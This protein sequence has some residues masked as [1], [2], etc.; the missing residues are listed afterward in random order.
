MSNFT[1]RICGPEDGDITK[2]PPT[3][4]PHYKWI[5]WRGCEKTEH[6][7]EFKDKCQAGY[8][9]ATADDCGC[10]QDWDWDTCPVCLKDQGS[11]WESAT[12]R[13]CCWDCSKQKADEDADRHAKRKVEKLEH[14]EW[15]WS[16][17]SSDSSD[18]DE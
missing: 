12:G 16:D 9:R 1:I 2:R 15:Y 4:A 13:S 6:K 8:T 10:R 18:T 17:H 7:W 5:S 14:P 3:I 11:K